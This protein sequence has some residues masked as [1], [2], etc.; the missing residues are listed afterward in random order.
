MVAYVWTEAMLQ[1][2]SILV[3]WYTSLPVY[4]YTST[5]G[6]GRGKREKRERNERATS[7]K[8][9]LEDEF[10]TIRKVGIFDI[11]STCSLIKVAPKIMKLQNSLAK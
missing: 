7:V 11:D 9:F 10:P 2:T 6:E 8:L 5:W 1:Y 4:P 3:C